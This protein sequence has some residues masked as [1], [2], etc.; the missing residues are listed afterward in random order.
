MA[1]VNRATLIGNLGKDPEFR[2]TPGGQPVCNFSIACSEKWTDKAGQKQ[3]KTEWINIVLWGRQAE[4]ANQYLK[5]GSSVYIEGKIQTRSWD[6]KN[7]VKRYTTEVV[8]QNIQLL[9]GKQG[10][11]QTEAQAQDQS[12][13][14]QSQPPRSTDDLPANW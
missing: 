14:A 6:D 13:P 4:I 7:G 3:E 8:G 9:G 5:K 10:Q 1:S 11:P 12:Q 2:V